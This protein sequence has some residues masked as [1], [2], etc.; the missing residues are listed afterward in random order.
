MEHSLSTRGCPDH[1]GAQVAR[2]GEDA[3]QCSIDHKV[4]DFKN[5]FKTMTGK[6]VP[7]TFVENQTTLYGGSEGGNSEAST[8]Y[9]KLGLDSQ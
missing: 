3:W 1:Y 5:G 7:G 2:V 6:M 4:Y 8:R 9:S